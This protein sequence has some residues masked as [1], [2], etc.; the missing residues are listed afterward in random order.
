MDGPQDHVPTP[1]TGSVTVYSS[2]LWVG[3]GQ[4]GARLVSTSST[5]PFV[6]R[7]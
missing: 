2:E 7:V 5:W 4:A 1:V 3:L 6:K